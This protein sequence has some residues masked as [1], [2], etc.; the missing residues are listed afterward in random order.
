[1]F[2]PPPVVVQ[3]LRRALNMSLPDFSPNGVVDGELPP[4]QIALAYAY[5]VVLTDIA[6]H[7]ST[8]VPKLVGHPKAEYIASKVF[9]KGG[10]HPVPRTIH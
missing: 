1:M 7:L 10:G 4:W 5:H 3:L 9:L 2:K 8:P 6:Q